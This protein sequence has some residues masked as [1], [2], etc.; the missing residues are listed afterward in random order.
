VRLVHELA[1]P[2][3]FPPFLGSGPDAYY[4][5]VTADARFLTTPENS[6]LLLKGAHTGPAFLP[7]EA[8]IIQS[9]LLKE[10][11]ARG[12]S[13]T[14]GPTT[15]FQPRSLAEALTRFGACM[16]RTTWDATYGQGTDQGQ[17]MGCHTTGT[18]GAFLSQSSG[19][20]F[21]MNRVSPYILKLVLSTTNSDGTFKDL[22]PGRRWELKG[23]EGD[24]GHPSFLMTQDRIDATNSFVDQTLVRFHDYSD[25]CQQP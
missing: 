23:G 20:T 2:S 13:V 24:A 7:N 11:Q 6:L 19:D 18:G 25:A 21:E 3:G 15:G 16:Q 17:C 12:S 14:G 10:I 9:W 22:V 4:A 1:N 8:Q 5:A